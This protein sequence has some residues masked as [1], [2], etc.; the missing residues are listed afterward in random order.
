MRL[1]F[2]ILLALC[3][4]PLGADT[5]ETIS[6]CRLIPSDYND[7]DS[8]HIRAAGKER[9]F[10]LYFVD[11]PETSD[12]YRAR[13]K[14]QAKDLGL[15][16]KRLFELAREATTFSE[17]KLQGNFTVRTRWEDAKGASQ[18]PRYY[19][20]IETP[21]GDLAELLV[22]AGLVR[23]RGHFI[24]HPRGIPAARYRD[25]LERLESSAKTKQ[26]GAWGDST[27]PIEGP[28]ATRS[29]P[30]ET[31]EKDVGPTL[32]EIPAF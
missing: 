18:L 1:L 22:A 26:L 12:D 13:T 16:K 8:F 15:T 23:I 2:A 30:A 28:T 19:A 20:V 17:A 14:S 3:A 9:I 25:L 31:S 21:E 11:T 10:R 29:R 32:S 27:H 5:W 6:N 24:D 4:T 7:G